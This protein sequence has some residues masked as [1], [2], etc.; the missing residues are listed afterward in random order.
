MLASHALGQ[1]K[2]DYEKV[3]RGALDQ[4]G[5]YSFNFKC[6]FDTGWQLPGSR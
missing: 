3:V 5:F 2:L 1:A 4:I 6:R